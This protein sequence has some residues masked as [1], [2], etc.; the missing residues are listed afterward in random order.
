MGSLD[1]FASSASSLRPLR[2]VGPLPHSYT[3][4]RPR[5]I[6]KEGGPA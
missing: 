6:G 3:P 1:F 4:A 2:P 5:L